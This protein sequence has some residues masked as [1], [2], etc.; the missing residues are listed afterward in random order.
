ML[1]PTVDPLE[2]LDRL[3]RVMRPLRP[4]VRV[5]SPDSRMTSAWSYRPA[6]LAWVKQQ[7]DVTISVC[8]PARNEERTIGRIVETVKSELQDD[9]AL[10]DEVLV[11]DDGSTDATALVATRCR[12]ARPRGR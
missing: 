12:R 1:N 2:S 3:E 4:V 5:P 8:L 6:D 9:V 10:V 7:A 11:L